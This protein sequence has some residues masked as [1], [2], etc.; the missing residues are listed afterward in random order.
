MKVLGRLVMAA[1]LIVPVGVVAATSAG[2]APNPNHATCASVGTAGTLTSTTKNG[3]KGGG[4]LYVK[5][6]PQQYTVASSGTCTGNVVTTYSLK[7]KVTTATAVNCQNINLTTLGGSG[8]FKWETDMGS[9]TANI[10]VQWTGKT[11]LKFQGDVVS[12][13]SSTNVFKGQHIKGT[14]TT[15]TSLN[16]TANGGNC[17][18]TVPLT[19]FH[20][21]TL[22]FS[23]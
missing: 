7:A 21:N 19:V 13:N 10:H 5:K 12:T 1:A 17:S 11:S 14:I 22:G 8:T 20:I 18:S 4:L 23:L 9:S 3:Q 16:A 2:A 6:A 15:A